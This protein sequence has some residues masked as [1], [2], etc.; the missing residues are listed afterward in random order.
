MSVILSESHF[1]AH[2]YIMAPMLT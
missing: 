1:D 2:I